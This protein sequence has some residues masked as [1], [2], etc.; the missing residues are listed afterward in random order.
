[1]TL[2][3]QAAAKPTISVN[4][5]EL[6]NERLP[7]VPESERAWP[8]LLQALEA[9]E[10][11]PS[12]NETLSWRD[13]YWPQFREWVEANQR[14]IELA[15]EAVR[16]PHLG[17]VY[18]AAPSEAELRV[19]SGWEWERRPYDAQVDPLMTLPA[20]TAGA[21]NRVEKALYLEVLTAVEAGNSERA[22]RAIESL[23]RLAGLTD[24]A[25]LFID[26]LVGQRIRR[27]VC[28]VIAVT[29]EHNAGLLSDEDLIKLDTA[30]AGIAASG[31]NQLRLH[32]ERFSFYDLLQRLYTDDGK[33]SGILTRQALYLMNALSNGT[34]R[35]YEPRAADVPMACYLNFVVGDR[36][37]QRQKYDEIMDLAEAWTLQPRWEWSGNPVEAVLESLPADGKRYLPLGIFCPALG[38]AAARQEQTQQWLDVAQ[39]TIA[40][41]R[42]RRM[43]G[44][45][46][47]DLQALTPDFLEIIPP[48]RFDGNPLKYR[49]ID[50]QPVLYSVGP[51]GDDDD[52][53]WLEDDAWLWMP[54]EEGEQPR[55]G[56]V[57]FFDASAGGIQ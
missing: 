52:G 8:I 11:A 16:K 50:G 38:M 37:T 10:E 25:V 27:K 54:L 39:T 31:R 7:D 13:E 41:E 20:P 14:G 36:R 53:Q 42:C 49:L 32:N 33:G 5:V 17:Y 29:L 4:Y 26:Q 22:V 34:E 55:D 21:F 46:P 30:I 35:Q 15:Q 51:D 44:N 18:G 12:H 40:I 47:A 9:M 57:L 56:D 45:W 19:W 1:M 24:E 23:L 43:R 6:L 3:R 28:K 2:L 48:D